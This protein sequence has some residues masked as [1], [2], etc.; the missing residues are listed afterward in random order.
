MEVWSI[1][2]QIRKKATVTQK[3]ILQTSANFNLKKKDYVQNWEWNIIVIQNE[4]WRSETKQI[5]LEPV[6]WA[7]SCR[8]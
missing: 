3:K 2:S 8:F 7:A 4:R 5:E 1:D 6:Q